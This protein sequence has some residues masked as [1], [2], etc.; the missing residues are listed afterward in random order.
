MDVE[1]SVCKAHEGIGGGVIDAGIVGVAIVPGFDVVASG[2][3]I[4]GFND[5]AGS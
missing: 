2:E 3:V 4:L 5:A 1:F